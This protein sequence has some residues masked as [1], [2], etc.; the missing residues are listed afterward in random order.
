MTSLKAVGFGL[1]GAMALAAAS[2]PAQ[3]ADIGRDRSYKDGPVNDYI[4]AIGWSGF[5]VGVNAGVVGEDNEDVDFTDDAVFIG[6]GHLGYN[7][8]RNNLVFGIEGDVGVA[9]TDDFDYLASIRGRIGVSAGST[10][11]YATG[12]AAFIGFGEDLAG[13]D[14]AVTGYVAGLGLDH[15]L[16]ENVSVGVE[17]LYYGFEADDLGSDEDI[18]LWTARARLTYHLG[19]GRGDSLK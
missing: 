10:L 5:Y 18:N 6:G 17:A 16:R 2:A 19:G 3:A 4:P 7:W 11:L 8:Q 13:D 15:K 1:V 9:D 14:E 12:G